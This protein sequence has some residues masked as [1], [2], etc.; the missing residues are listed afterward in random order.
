[1]DEFAP[2]NLPLQQAVSPSLNAVRCDGV[3][4]VEV[5]IVGE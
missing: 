2:R 5:R 4:G 3:G 1:M